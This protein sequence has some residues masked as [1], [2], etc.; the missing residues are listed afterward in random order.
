M[1]LVNFEEPVFS[2]I[3]GE[4]ILTGV[5]SVFVRTQGCDFTCGWCDTK[6]SWDLESGT[7]YAVDEVERQVKATHVQHVVITGGNPF[8][9]A[10][11]CA[12]LALRLGAAGRHVTV[13]T[14]GSVFDQ[15]LCLAADLLSLSP[16]LHNFEAAKF[17]KFLSCQRDHGRKRDTQIK[18][19]VEHL[20]DVD[21]VMGI[22]WD[23]QEFWDRY[24]TCQPHYI[25][26]PEYGKGRGFVHEVCGAI[27]ARS[28]SAG[29]RNPPVVRVMG[30]THKLLYML[31]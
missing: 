21:R 13:E 12:V 28:Q 10:S 2:T 1:K 16:K 26:Q 25:V 4:G 31:R 22:F 20:E 6:K 17:Y 5:P 29:M 23:V 19:V 8:L 3:Q 7:E 9:Q 27:L 15:Q 24:S 18:V 11:E 30:Q 14:Q